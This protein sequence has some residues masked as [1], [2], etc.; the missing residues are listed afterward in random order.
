MVMN[1]FPLTCQIAFWGPAEFKMDASA[2]GGM[3]FTTVKP[4]TYGWR[5]FIGGAETGEAGN[6]EI[7]P[8]ASCVFV[9]DKERV[10]IRYGCK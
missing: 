9:C 10:S 8:G 7:A 2:N 3:A 6:L 1:T 4:G 5:A